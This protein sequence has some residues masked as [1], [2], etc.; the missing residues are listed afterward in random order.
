MGR[1]YLLLIY[2]LME[3]AKPENYSIKHDLCWSI[4]RVGVRISRVLDEP[5]P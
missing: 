2:D 4:E 5:F 1:L 3:P